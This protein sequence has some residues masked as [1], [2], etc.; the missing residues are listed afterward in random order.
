MKFSSLQKVREHIHRITGAKELVEEINSSI[1]ITEE[2]LEQ[3][4]NTEM[5]CYKF[6]SKNGNKGIVVIIKKNNHFRYWIG[7][8]DGEI[9]CIV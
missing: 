2:I 8:E 5:N 3:L 4:A 7:K 1:I 6:V 9:F